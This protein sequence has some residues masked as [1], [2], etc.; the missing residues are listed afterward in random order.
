MN[1]DKDST[2]FSIASIYNRWQNNTIR[3]TQERQ[4]R[5]EVPSSRVVRGMTKSVVEEQLLEDQGDV[6]L[7]RSKRPIGMMEMLKQEESVFV[8]RANVE[9]VRWWCD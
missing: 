9:Q 6:Q 3:G 8:R 5:A 2:T 1:I 4:M 7:K